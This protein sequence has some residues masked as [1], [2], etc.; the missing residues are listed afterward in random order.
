MS[1]EMKMKLHFGVFK[2]HG[3]FHTYT[4]KL[5]STYGFDL[6]FSWE[7]ISNNS[8]ELKSVVN[9]KSIFNT[10]DSGSSS[11]YAPIKKL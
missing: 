5:D 9:L 3:K 10:S 8:K 1:L 2:A 7:N 6:V 11:Y 4:L